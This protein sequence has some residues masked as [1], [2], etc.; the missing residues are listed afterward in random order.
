M[1][2]LYFTYGTRLD[3]EPKQ[4]C[5][6]APGHLLTTDVDINTFHRSTAHTP[7]RPLLRSAEQQRMKLKKGSKLLPCVG[8]S[9]AKG[10]SALVNK[11]T[12]YRSDKKLGS[13]F[14]DRSGMKASK[15]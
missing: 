13:V 12:E 6:I 4:A 2:N 3:A 8:C 14:V 10:I 1:G 7:H 15:S 11:V 5:A 9:M